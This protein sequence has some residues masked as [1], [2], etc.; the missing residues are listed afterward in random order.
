MKAFYLLM[1]V[2]GAATTWYFNI[3]AI[4]E[5]GN[6]FTPVAFFMVGFQGSAMLGSVAADFW[7]GSFVSL[8]WMVAEGRRLQMPR[9]WVYVVLTFMIA[10]AC[11]LP[12]FLYFRQRHL[13]AHDPRSA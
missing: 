8:V 7:I 6:E 9:I 5:I 11:S 2:V 3:R 12:L 1:A 4:N 13:D 10:W